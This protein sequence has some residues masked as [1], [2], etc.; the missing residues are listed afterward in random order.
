MLLEPLSNYL[1]ARRL[2]FD[3]I[4]SSRM[5]ILNPFA[6]RLRSAWI[7]GHRPQ[8]VFVCTHNSRRSHLAQ[9]WTA[10][11]AAD[12][13]LPIDSWSGGTEATEFD[14]RAVAS[15][16]RAGFEIETAG[17]RFN[18]GYLT[19]FDSKMSPMRCFSKVH[20]EPPNP[21][22]DFIA[23]MVCDEADRGCPHLSGASSRLSI[24]FLDP[25]IA[26]DTPE[27]TRTYDQRCRQVAREML[28]T[29]DRA[30]DRG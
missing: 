29:I 7:D 18:A 13:G 19:R 24:P 14:R 15:L 4:E 17:D 9:L 25:K 26:D 1:K 28:W 6:D 23:V 11:A 21:G 3:R 12:R 8:V 22:A 2:E 20:D 16:K 30:A 5:E 10:A 27:E